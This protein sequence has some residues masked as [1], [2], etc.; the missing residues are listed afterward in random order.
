MTGMLKVALVVIGILILI[1]IVSRIV[2]F[3]LG[4]ISLLLPL[5]IVGFIAYLFY[6]LITHKCVAGSHRIFH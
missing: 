5:L 1:S 3:A 6:R 4:L 2:N